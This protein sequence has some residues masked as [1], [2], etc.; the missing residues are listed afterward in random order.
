MQKH[1]HGLLTTLVLCS[2]ATVVLCWTGIA[3]AAPARAP[4][5]SITSQ[6]ERPGSV[7]DSGEPDVGQNGRKEARAPEDSRPRW[8]WWLPGQAGLIQAMPFF[9]LG[10]F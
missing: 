7:P 2:L 9:W 5:L 1:R 3:K 6:S 8:Q 4:A 10:R